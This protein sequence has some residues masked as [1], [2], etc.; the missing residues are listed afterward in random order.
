MIL[1]SEEANQGMK[2]FVYINTFIYT[3]FEIC[4]KIKIT[5]QI[6][7]KRLSNKRC[8]ENW[9]KYEIV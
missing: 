1:I 8:L 3:C 5:L 2:I 9:F 7:E 4:Y 6:K